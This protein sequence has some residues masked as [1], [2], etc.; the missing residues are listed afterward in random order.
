MGYIKAF[1][2]IQKLYVGG[3]I[4]SFQCCW[5]IT[6]FGYLSS[7]NASNACYLC[8]LMLTICKHVKLI[9]VL[10]QIN[11]KTH[12]YCIIVKVKKKVYYIFL[13]TLLKCFLRAQK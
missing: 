4:T 12:G 3:K 9:V 5:L 10:I 6:W 13:L 7:S 8:P 2:A 11:S 1:K